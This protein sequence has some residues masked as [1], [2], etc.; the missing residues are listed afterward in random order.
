MTMVEYFLEFILT[1]K[2]REDVFV[3]N[4]TSSMFAS[5]CMIFKNL[6]NRLKVQMIFMF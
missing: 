2:G 5:H 1:V 6:L 3:K 4:D